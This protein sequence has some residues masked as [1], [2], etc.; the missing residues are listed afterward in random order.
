MKISE[1]T[2]ITL[3][4]GVALVGGIFWL[5]NLDFQGRANAQSIEAV[6]HDVGLVKRTCV[7]V[8]LLKKHFKLPTTPEECE[9][10]E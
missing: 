5:A 6:K 9:L 8:L 1:D 7:N 4:L 3:G 10:K 2:K